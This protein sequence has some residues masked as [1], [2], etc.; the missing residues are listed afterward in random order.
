MSFALL[1]NTLCSEFH[2]FDSV[3]AGAQDLTAA[4]RRYINNK[5]GPEDRKFAKWAKKMTDQ[6]GPVSGGEIHHDCECMEFTCF[7]GQ[8]T[9]LAEAQRLAYGSPSEQSTEENES[10]WTDCSESELAEVTKQLDS[11]CHVA[12]CGCA[13]EYHLPESPGNSADASL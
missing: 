3:C 9:D 11:A 7:C 8:V 5:M 12:D 1:D 4:E 10:E 6:M 13:A 2:A